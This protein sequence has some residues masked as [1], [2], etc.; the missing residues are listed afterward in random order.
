MK[1]HSLYAIFCIF[2]IVGISI[3]VGC[4]GGGSP[5][6]GTPPT[7]TGKPW[8]GNLIVSETSNVAYRAKLDT[9]EMTK[10]PA[11]DQRPNLTGYWAGYAGGKMLMLYQSFNAHFYDPATLV[12]SA[13]DFTIS[14]GLATT[15]GAKISRDGA[16]FAACWDGDGFS[17]SVGLFRVGGDYVA[18]IASPRDNLTSTCFR[19]D[20]LP[21]QHLVYDSGS[22]VVVTNGTASQDVRY[23]YPRL[24][25]GW[26]VSGT[27]F[28]VDPSGRN[29][30]WSA[31]LPKRDETSNDLQV[32]IVANIDGTSFRQITDYAESEKSN[33]LTWIRHGKATWSPDGR[34]IAF[35]ISTP[36]AAPYPVPSGSE[37]VGE[38]TPVVIVPADADKVI[39]DPFGTQVP[40]SLLY[41]VPSTGKL[42]R[43]C[44]PLIWT[45]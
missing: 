31:L 25:A 1:S 29:I 36:F 17:S 34:Y 5:D 20:W 4:G 6:P 41:T 22:D 24:P 40:D 13:P 9:G 8:T 16:Y 27:V 43:S 10:M 21:N 42:L 7:A 26:K 32:L 15:S 11:P 35:G 18:K 23:P 38:C 12:K 39:I 33:P 45:E 30:L 14:T 37:W 44:A 3:G 19:F 28:S 2:S